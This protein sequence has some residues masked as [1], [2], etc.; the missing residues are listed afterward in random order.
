MNIGPVLHRSLFQK[1]SFTYRVTDTLK[2][3]GTH[4]LSFRPQYF[5]QLYL[6]GKSAF[7]EA[8]GVWYSVNEEMKYYESWPGYANLYIDE[9]GFRLYGTTGFGGYCQIDAGYWGKTQGGNQTQ[10][11]MSFGNYLVQSNKIK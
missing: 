9:E 2:G 4:R 10:G 11:W 7:V 6:S 8:H 3:Y 1:D 5:T